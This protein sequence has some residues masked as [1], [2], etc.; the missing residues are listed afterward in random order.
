MRKSAHKQ[1]WENRYSLSIV[2]FQT[3]VGASHGSQP[4]RATPHPL[5]VSS[6]ACKPCTF[7]LAKHSL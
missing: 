2:T 7:S 6:E 3:P 4:L 5:G 1:A